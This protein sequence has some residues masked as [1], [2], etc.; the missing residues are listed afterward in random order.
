MYNE[1]SYSYY[2]LTQYPSFQTVTVLGLVSI[3]AMFFIRDFFE[4]VA[5]NTSRCAL[6]GGCAV[7]GVIYLGIDVLHNSIVPPALTS[8]T[9]HLAVGVISVMISIA[10]RSSLL[11]KNPGTKETVMDTY[12]N[13]I[14]LPGY[15]YLLVTLAPVI[16][17]CGSGWHSF[18][19]ALLAIT[20]GLTLLHDMHTGRLDQPAFLRD[21]GLRLPIKD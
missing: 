19:L 20:Y 18:S 15:I 11:R 12:H 7:L 1:A 13:W 16:L 2:L 6:W 4:G 9:F 10:V 21:H 3:G 17:V 14:L 5:Y 8:G